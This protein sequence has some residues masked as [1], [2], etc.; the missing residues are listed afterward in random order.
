MATNVSGEKIGEIFAEI[1]L[2][3]D[4]IDSD[5]KDLEKRGLKAANKL[6]D[7]FSRAKVSVNTKLMEK[8][9]A[10]VE[11]MQAKL[12][13]KLEQKLSMN[14]DMTSINR[15]KSALDTINSSLSG[16]K[17]NQEDVVNQASKWGM[18]AT[19]INQSVQA[20]KDF[21]MQM[22]QLVGQSVNSA[23][24]LNVLR[25]NF[26]GSAED[27][28]LFK[29]ATAGTVSEAKL[30]ELSNQSS[31]L[32]LSLQQQA[33]FFSLAEDAADK[34]GGGVEA[35]M[36]GVIRASEGS[37]RAIGELGIQ[38][39]AFEERTKELA[40]AEGDSIQNLDAETQK[41]IRLRAIIELSGIT[42]DDVKKKTKD[43][44]DLIEA[45]G[46]SFEEAKIKLGNFILGGLTPL[47]KSFDESN[48][49][50]KNLITGILSLGGIIIGAIPI[51][52]QLYSAKKIF[53]SAS[54]MSASAVAVETKAV[55]D[56]TVAKTA[57]LGLMARFAGALGTIG[58]TAL[59]I[60]AVG[61]VVLSLSENIKGLDVKKAED[62]A[63]AL[64]QLAKDR[65]SAK[66]LGFD[67]EVG[68]SSNKIQSGSINSGSLIR[69][70]QLNNRGSGLITPH[71]WAHEI[72]EVVERWTIAGKTVQQVRDRID[73]LTKTQNNLVVGS[74]SWVNNLKEIARLSKALSLPNTYGKSVDT[75]TLGGYKPNFAV[76]GS[77]K[78]PT[79]KKGNYAPDLKLGTGAEI[80]EDWVR[81]SEVAGAAM[82][83]FINGVSQGLDVLKIKV[84]ENANFMAQAFVGFAN[85][86]M[87]AI[88]QIIAKWAVLNLISAIG[89][90]GGINLFSMLGLAKGHSGGSF[91]GTSSG[92]MKMAGGG[93][94]MVPFGYPNDSFP[95]MV[96]TGGR[97]TVTPAGANN[98]NDQA[99]VNKLDRVVNSIHALSKI[100]LQNREV[101][102]NFYLDSKLLA[103]SV[104]Q[105][106]NDSTRGN[107]KVNP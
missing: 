70:S 7:Q 24:E 3:L 61:A 20:V 4:K 10:D 21:V 66:A 95:L 103:T 69:T 27:L 77:F 26:T 88:E 16:L 51:V 42:L 50:I 87:Q 94:F 80:M 83:G 12:R 73:E 68:T 23:A 22:K 81:Q 90:Y 57:N 75:L 92:V 82:D 37:A 65:S 59:G 55:I 45:A 36:E 14:A 38:K 29:K 9:F 53:A 25:E 102:S 41:R 17:R 71:L 100:T 52:V 91:V 13:A 11:K 62:M 104:T 31:A 48:S 5:F 39:K 105:N 93:S 15:T 63:K 96:E 32:G 33:I 1:K 19:G 44:K 56:N 99:I 97:V 54:L 46:V 34:F 40:K 85:A 2:K 101:I 58:L 28:D 79:E 98:F 60:G 67:G 6:E 86:A 72:K 18:I 107:V 84:A 49:G 76:S 78:N 89:G 47:L 64:D 8:S 30:I 74:S 35:G 43:E 106:Q